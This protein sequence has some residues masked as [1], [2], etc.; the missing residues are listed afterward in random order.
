MILFAFGAR[1]CLSNLYFLNIKDLVLKR[2]H[3]ATIFL[4]YSIRLTAAIKIR[5]HDIRC[6]YETNFSSCI[7]DTIKYCL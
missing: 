2:S 7:M 3:K 4:Y 1:Q 6:D 5:S